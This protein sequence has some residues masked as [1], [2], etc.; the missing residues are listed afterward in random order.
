MAVDIEDNRIVA[1]QGDAE[2][3]LTQGFLCAKGLACVEMPTD[4]LRLRFPRERVGDTWHR[5]TWADALEKIATRL[6]EIISRHGSH[7]VGLYYG[8]GNPTS[9]INYMMADGFLRALGS[10]RMYNVL[11]L[12]FT[13]RYYVMEKMY[14][15]QFCVSQPDLEHTECLLMFGSNPMVSL[16]HPGIIASLKHLKKRGGKLI[17]VDPRRTETARMA[18]LHVQVT[19]GT[20]LF[21]LQGIYSHIIENKM[22]DADF[23]QAHCDG[24]EFFLRWKP[25]T[26]AAAESICGVAA[27]TIVRVA[28]TFAGAKTA[29]A[30]CKLGINTSHHG[31]LTYWLVEALNAIT[32]NVDRP[33][34][35]LFNP[36]VLDLDM[37]SRMAVG[38]KKRRSR[39]GAYPYITGSYPASVLADEILTDSPDRIRALIVDAGD[40]SLV[41]PDSKRLDEALARLDILVS[42]DVCMNETAQRAH[43][44]LPA[45]N[46]L[47]KDDLYVTF[48]DHFPYPFAQWSHKVMEPPDEARAE[49]EIFRDL[50]RRMR[51]PILNQRMLDFLFRMSEHVGRLIGKRAG[52]SFNPRNYYKMLLGLL[53]KVKFQE[54]MENPH[55][56]KAGDITWG[57]TLRR[58]STRS[59][60]I[61]VAPRE[62]IERLDRACAVSTTPEFPYLLISGERSP[63]TKNTNLR[64]LKSLTTRQ[65]G[66]FAR[67]NSEDAAAL[68]V[69][70]GEILE[71]STQRGT[72]RV[73]ARVTD[74]IRQ[75]VISIGHGWG[76]KI[77][78]P[79][80]GSPDG[81]QGTNVNLLTDT[82]TLDTFTGMPVYNAIPCSVR[83]AD[84][85]AMSEL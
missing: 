43:F 76:R 63:Y 42:I 37:L 32:G 78:E 66:N 54:L 26:P 59:R 38:R 67:I 18:D 80:S 82:G 62:F 52:Y 57:S 16:D 61:E 35:L 31:T 30:V 20:D 14:G 4:P 45:A 22:C 40:P 64:G 70:D 19:P 25:M 9:S 79:E 56:L 77:I 6:D 60:R 8:A 34:G 2:H 21:L 51:I 44:A 23:L 27:E 12:E 71:I 17:V 55:G 53:G 13:N 49:W 48:P 15:R 81:I 58:L 65:S 39:V 10:D 75:G 74:D 46:F 47:E 11:T 83:K 68:A 7:A 28:E 50:S 24:G 33:G 72:V 3:P 69:Q 73:R 29:C 84:R 36:G 1:F 5:I 41:F 85:P